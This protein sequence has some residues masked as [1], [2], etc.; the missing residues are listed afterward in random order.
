MELCSK[1]QDRG[2]GFVRALERRQGCGCRALLLAL[3]LLPAGG[4][5]AAPPAETTPAQPLLPPAQTLPP[6]TSTPP[7]EEVKGAHVPAGPVLPQ[8]EVYLIDLQAA[9]RLAERSNPM[10]GVSRANVQEA[11]ALYHGARVLMLPDF[12]AGTNYHLHQGALQTSFGLIRNLNEQS[13]YVGGGARTLAAETVAIPMFR[14]FGN[15]G[16]ALYQPLAARQIVA[17]RTATVKATENSVLLDVAG[18]YLQLMAAEARLQAWTLSLADVNELVRIT[19][20]FA[21]TGQGR[22]GDFKRAQCDALLF[23]VEEQ[24]VQADAAIASNRLS[25]LLLLDPAVRLTTPQA[26]IEM[27]VLV[28]PERSLESLIDLAL[29]NRPELAA[30]SAS[31]AAANTQVRLE[32]QRPFLPTL[33]VGFSAGGFGGGSNQTALGIDSMWQRFGGRDDFDASAIWTLQD[34]GLGNVA[35]IRQRVAAREG[36]VGQRM[37]DSAMVR[38]QVTSAFADVEASRRR[39]FAVQTELEV[40][41]QGAREELNRI[42]AAE[43]LPIEAVNSVD[44]LARARQNLIGAIVDYNLAEFRLFVALGETPGAATPDP[45]RH[46]ALKPEQCG[47]MPGQLR[48]QGLAKPPAVPSPPPCPAPRVPQAAAQQASRTQTAQV[49]ASRQSAAAGQAQP[50]QPA[51][52]APSQAASSTAAAPAQ[53]PPQAAPTTQAATGPTPGQTA[54][55]QTATAQ[56]PANPS[57]GNQT[58]LT[59]KKSS[60]ANSWMSAVRSAASKAR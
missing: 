39:V 44:L 21:T 9:L 22:E 20:N 10:L 5:L 50:V 26:P 56:T 13:L 55:A 32:R 36:L 33:F 6:P 29:N 40:A 38:Q 42:R 35:T 30:D 2:H 51:P 27:L 8:G 17:A 18:A 48:Q 58:Q 37:L 28:D 4:A 31:I 47:T 52:V 24:G 1:P 49:P 34:M 16:D 3:C 53:A 59:K 7:A 19:G 54:A 60:T 41:K 23:V 57:P 15:V 12:N 11:L 43:G 25:Q 46:E 45:K 14:I